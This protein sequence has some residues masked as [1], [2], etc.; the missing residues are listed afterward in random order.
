MEKPY[1]VL[2]PGASCPSKIWPTDRYARLAEKLSKNYGCQ[3]V[4]IGR[5]RERLIA[6]KVKEHLSALPVIDLSG[7]LSLGML[8]RLLKEARLLISNDSG[9]VHVATA[10]GT[11][12][13]SIFGRN[14][15]GLS[16]R[17]WGP[18]GHK[19]RVIHK[20]VGCPVCLAHNCRINFLCLDVIS[21]EDLLK[22]VSLVLNDAVH[23]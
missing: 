10:V 8:G 13:I 12:V 7:K 17:R 3:I 4:L 2:N 21:V 18:L 19:A 16:P 15:P 20:E 5:T 11:P 22:E 23:S 1:V 14:L 9:P 6:L